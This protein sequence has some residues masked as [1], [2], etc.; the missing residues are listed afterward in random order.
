VAARLYVDGCSV[1]VLT[2]RSADG[3]TYLRLRG[4]NCDPE[5]E[6][7]GLYYPVTRS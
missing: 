6:E 2:G 1:A 4:E 5:G 3:H 7:L